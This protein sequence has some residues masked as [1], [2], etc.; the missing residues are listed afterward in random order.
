MT[1]KKLQETGELIGKVSHYY[2]NIGVAIIELSST[3]KMGDTIRIVGS[4][5][6]DFTQSVE[7]MEIDRK[8]V[9][10]AEKGKVIGV[11]VKEKVKGGCLVY[12]I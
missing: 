4:D 6:V 11:K 12:K 5:N 1:E 3:L 9:E 8:K 10:T 7:S 2:G